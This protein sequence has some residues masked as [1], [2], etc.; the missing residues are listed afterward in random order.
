MLLY[1]G[2]NVAVREPV[3]LHSRTSLDFGPGFYLTSDWDQAVK[4]ARR[5]TRVRSAGTPVVST[6]TV[7]EALWSD[8]SILRFSGA[9]REW[10]QT[11]VKYRTNQPVEGEYDVLIGP[12]ADDR[13]IDVINQY[14]TG[15]YPEDIALRLLL[16]MRFVDQWALKTDRALSTLIWKEAVSV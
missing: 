11:V 12:V 16:P 1:H 13:T 2:S 15:A 3:L 9:D 8:L 7:D 4:W 10:L 6:F 5:K 14:I